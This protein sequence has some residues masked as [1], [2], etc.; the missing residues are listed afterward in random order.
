MQVIASIWRARC[1]TCVEHA[2]IHA[3]GLRLSSLLCSVLVG[4]SWHHARMLPLLPRNGEKT[5]D[6]DEQLAELEAGQC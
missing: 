1:G 6:A 4:L 2:R 3:P 5:L